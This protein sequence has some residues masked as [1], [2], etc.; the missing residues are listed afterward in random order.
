[1][2]GRPPPF[3]VN[4]LKGRV[5]KETATCEH[6]LTT[7]QRLLL[8]TLSQAHF[9]PPVPSEQPAG[10]MRSDAR[11]RFWPHA[12]ILPLGRPDRPSRAG[13]NNV[14]LCPPGKPQH[15]ATLPV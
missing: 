12:A 7:A 3:T 8:L 1:M 4:T 14:G 13:G 9:P 10:G 6:L 15:R 11:G 5:V 2:E